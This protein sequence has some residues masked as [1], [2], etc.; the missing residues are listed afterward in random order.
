MTQCFPI[1][2]R[3]RFLAPTFPGWDSL[4]GLAHFMLFLSPFRCWLAEAG[5]TQR[6]PDPG[7]RRPG[8]RTRALAR[9]KALCRRQA[10]AGAVWW[11]AHL[12]AV[13]L[14]Q[15]HVE[16]GAVGQD[17][18]AAPHSAQDVGPHGPGQ[19]AHR[20]LDQ[21]PGRWRGRRGT[22]GLLLCRRVPRPAAS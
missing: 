13:A 2:K 4:I 20:R 5:S 9:S 11:R 12:E 21:L 6:I 18:A 14:D 3:S 10:W 8:N 16:R 19:F 7:A 15:V 22:R 1:I 17:L